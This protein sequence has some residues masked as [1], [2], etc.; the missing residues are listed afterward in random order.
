[1]LIRQEKCALVEKSKPQKKEHRKE[2]QH[3]IVEYENSSK[4]AAM[5][6]AFECG[7]A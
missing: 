3:R 2:I 6:I 1:M 4:K 7:E 5:F